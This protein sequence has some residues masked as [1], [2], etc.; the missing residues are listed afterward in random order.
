DVITDENGN[1]NFTVTLAAGDYFVATATDPDGN[2]SEFSATRPLAPTSGLPYAMN[3]GESLT[4]YA[5]A[6][7][8]ANPWTYSW[9]LN[10]DGVFNDASGQMPTVTWAQLQALVPPVNDGPGTVAVQAQV[11]DGLGTVITLPASTL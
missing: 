10:G 3:E 1:A 2:T 11:N 9:D 8:G 6:A 5:A 7:P 4:L